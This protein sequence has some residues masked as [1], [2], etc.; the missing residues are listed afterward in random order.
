LLIKLDRAE[1]ARAVWREVQSAAQDAAVAAEAAKRLVAST[2]PPI[3]PPNPEQ[4]I[5]DLAKEGRH[6]EV[7]EAVEAEKRERERKREAVAR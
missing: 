7:I 1:E 5:Y 4:A 6:R 2:P 3:A